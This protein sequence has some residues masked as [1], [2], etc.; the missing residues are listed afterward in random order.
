VN[1]NEMNTTQYMSSVNDSRSPQSVWYPPVVMSQESES[2][3][4]VCTQSCS[5]LSVQQNQGN[6]SVREF[7]SYSPPQPQYPEVPSYPDSRTK[8]NVN[9]QSLVKEEE[10]TLDENE[11]LYKCDRNGYMDFTPGAVICDKYQVR[12][13]LGYGTFS[14]VFECDGVELVDGIPRHQ[15]YAVKVIRNIRKYRVTAINE[16]HILKMIGDNDPTNESCC[17]HLVDSDTFHGHPILAFPL[18]SQSIYSV[19]KSNS[20]RPFSYNDTIDILE[21]ICVGVAYMHSL[22]VINADLK[23]ENIVFVDDEVDTP[24]KQDSPYFSSRNSNRIKII[25]FG[26]AVIHQPESGRKHNHLIQ[27]LH[28]RAPEVVLNKEWDFSAD[29]W[30]IG[31][32]LVELIYGRLLFNTRCSIDHFNQM[33]Q[34]IGTPPPEILSNLDDKTWSKFFD[35]AG[36][37]NMAEAKVSPFQCC[38]LKT[39]FMEFRQKHC[40]DRIDDP[41]GYMLLDLC[42]KMLCWDP[43][44]RITARQALNHPVFQFRGN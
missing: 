19:M 20:Y 12:R 3:F 16:M 8:S 26:S 28:Y 10:E 41:R 25:D 15:K 21:Q 4:P 2:S 14:K 5:I 1:M 30:S 24:S 23:P 18:M 43:K 44:Q 36:N 13:Q 37:L 17:I 29:I 33:M 42:S 9:H 38:E 34:C 39:Y 22:N 32:I 40:N 31:C 6:G 11:M 35:E 27:T 7:G